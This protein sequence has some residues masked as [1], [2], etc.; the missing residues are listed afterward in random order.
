MGRPRND[1]LAALARRV[2]I[3]VW[4]R[5][6]TARPTM[7]VHEPFTGE[8]L[9]DVPVGTVDDVEHAFVRARRAQAEWAETPVR[10]RAVVLRRF[11]DRVHARREEILDVVQAESGKN[12]M[13]ALDEVLD[14]M[15]TARFYAD[16]GPGLL[17]DRR[18]PGAIP[19]FSSATVV[20]RPRGVVGMISPWNYPFSLP[21]GDG[22]A[23]LLAGNAI[24]HKPASL[25]PFSTLLGV[26]LWEEAGLPPDVWQVVPGSGRE[27]GGAVVDRCDFLMFTGSSATGARLGAQIGRRLVPFSAEL[28]GKN[29]MVVGAGADLEQVADIAVRA[30]FASAGQ[31][32]M[33]IE[34]I[35]VE[36]EVYDEFCDVFARRVQAMRLGAGYGWGPE[37]GSLVSEDQ[38]TV[39]TEHVADAVAKGATVLAGGHRRPDLGPLFHEPTVLVDVPA[40]ATCHAEE[41]FG[42]VV[43]V[44][45]VADLDEAVARANDS[46]Y[47]LTA[48]VFC[49]TP[50]QGYEVGTRIDAGMV[51]VDEGYP[52][53]WSSLAGPSGG[54]GISGVGY[55]HGSEGLL[56]YTQAHTIATQSRALNFGGP[57][58]LPQRVWGPALARSTNLLKYLKR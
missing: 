37:M 33:S 49:A 12:R 31:L 46:E 18:I 27:V 2:D 44:Y 29:P 22:L 40:D 26:E 24:V 41:T 15:L 57:G 55:R 19:L 54:T 30:C 13:S 53:A 39:V 14:A 35:Y 47:G 16:K 23:A 10:R 51:N 43:S 25:T 42:P 11:A 36:Q 58:S 1:R 7:T 28:G 21:M 3:P 4:Q 38:M 17:A 6:S 20:R 32:C 8:V 52:A 50:E 5:D 56:K 9:G 34:R 48:A 45:P